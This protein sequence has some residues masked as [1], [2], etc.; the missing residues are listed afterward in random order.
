[1][2][3]LQHN[4]EFSGTNETRNLALVASGATINIQLKCDN[5]FETMSSYTSNETLEITLKRGMMWRVSMSDSG[6]SAKAFISSK[7]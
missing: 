5:T 7:R 4:E 1:M 3:E 2:R 6:A